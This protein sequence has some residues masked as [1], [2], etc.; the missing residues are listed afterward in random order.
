LIEDPDASPRTDTVDATAASASAGWI[1]LGRLA[2][3]FEKDAG[4][5]VGMMGLRR[6]EQR[7]VAQHVEAI[8]GAF[9]SLQSFS[10]RIFHDGK[11]GVVHSWLRVKTP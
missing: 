9:R 4:L 10:H 1:D 5:L 7:A 8:I 6:G 11:Q 2:D 3:L